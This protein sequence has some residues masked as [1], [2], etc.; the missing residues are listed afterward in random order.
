MKFEKNGVVHEVKD[1]VQAAA[2]L[3]SGYEQVHDK[4]PK[5]GGGNSGNKQ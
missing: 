2:F 3:S 1:E 5:K 4:P